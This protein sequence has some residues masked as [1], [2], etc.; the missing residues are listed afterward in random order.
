MSDLD[1]FT[2]L[3]L[4]IDPQ[5]KA[6]SSAGATAAGTTLRTLE[7]ELAA[8]NA[9]HRSLH[10]LE[11]PHVVPPPPVPVNPKRSANV[12]KLRESGNAE[13][14]KQRYGE[15]I[16]FYTL[17]L[18][19]ALT[20][21]AWEPSQLVREEV[22]QLYSNRAQA[23]MQMAGWAEGAVDAEASVEAKRQGNAKA[24]LRR[25]RCLVEMGRL[26]EARDWV[27]KGLEVEGQEKELLELLKEVEGR[28]AQDKA[29]SA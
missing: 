7:A 3:P 1:T 21:P 9:L 26:E 22:H 28:I 17:G 20:R 16:K 29:S 2:L 23:H 19:M 5:S 18:Q 8:L 10:S 27:G 24:W 25:G 11:A 4:R 15:A 12:T 14:R 6:I 13:Y